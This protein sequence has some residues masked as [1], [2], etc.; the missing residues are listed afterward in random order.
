MVVGFVGL[1]VAGAGVRDKVVGSLLDDV[2]GLLVV[3][4]FGG[5]FKMIEG[6]RTH[7]PTL[8]EFP[9]NGHNKLFVA[10]LT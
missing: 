4:V 7:S 6:S 1:Y 10:I 9:E 5:G 2:A 8:G 3:F